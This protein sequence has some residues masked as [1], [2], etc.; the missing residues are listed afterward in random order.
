M[1]SFEEY[2]F[3][4]TKMIEDFDFLEYIKSNNKKFKD[5]RAGIL[6]ITDKQY[7]I[8][9]SRDYGYGDHL[10]AFSRLFKDLQG[11]GLLT[12]R[13]AEKIFL[14]GIK[15]YIIAKI[16]FGYK[17]NNEGVILFDRLENLNSNNLK[18]FY[19]FYNDYSTIIKTICNNNNFVVAYF[20][21]N[22]KIITSKDM[23]NLLAYVKNKKNK[24]KTID[25]E[26]KILGTTINNDLKITKKTIRK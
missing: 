6:V 9:Y 10:P 4:L 15:K 25:E 24:A 8:S 26:E 12:K 1:L 19:E 7:I 22:K 5:Y 23:D 18:L 17:N 3:D 2:N 14:E 20:D 11:G 21:E 13:K 16:Y